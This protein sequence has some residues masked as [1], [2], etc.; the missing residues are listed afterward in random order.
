VQ[1]PVVVLQVNPEG[2][3]AFDVHLFSHILVAV[4][5]TRPPPQR[6]SVEHWQK[7]GDVVDPAVPSYFAHVFAVDGQSTDPVQLATHAL[8]TG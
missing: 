5:Q 3:L 8:V 6:A 7:P 2:Q 4:L 1:F